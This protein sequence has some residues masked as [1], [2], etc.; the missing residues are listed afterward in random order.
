MPCWHFSLQ[1]WTGA[2]NGT[3]ENLIFSATVATSKES[4]ARDHCALTAKVPFTLYISIS[5][6]HI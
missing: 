6:L 2:W 3:L 5:F 4:Y 1:I